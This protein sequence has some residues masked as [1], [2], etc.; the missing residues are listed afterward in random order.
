M[1]LKHSLYLLT[2]SMLEG[3]DN[4]THYMVMSIESKHPY[5]HAHPQ[6]QASGHTISS[7]YTS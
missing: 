7:T 3:L 6:A 4:D 2:K 5:R 1:V